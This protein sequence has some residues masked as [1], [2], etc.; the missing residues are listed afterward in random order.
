MDSTAIQIIHPFIQMSI[1]TN[2][3]SQVAIGILRSFYRIFSINLD[4][5][6]CTEFKHEENQVST[7]LV[8]LSINSGQDSHIISDRL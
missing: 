8:L 6:L 1:V 4:Q 5:K 7:N 3:F 2:A